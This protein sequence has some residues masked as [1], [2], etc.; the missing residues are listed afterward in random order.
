VWA[1]MSSSRDLPDPGIEPESLTFPELA[2]PV[3]YCWFHLGSP[4]ENSGSYVR[5]HENGPF[6][7]GNSLG[8]V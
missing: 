8:V 6:T 3:L 2:G 7:Y 5:V 4:K 1:A